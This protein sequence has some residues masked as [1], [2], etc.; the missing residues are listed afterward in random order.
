MITSLED[1]FPPQYVLNADR[2]YLSVSTTSAGRTKLKDK[3]LKTTFAL[4]FFRY[5]IIPVKPEIALQMRLL[6]LSFILPSSSVLFFALIILCDGKDI[7]KAAS[8]PCFNKILKSSSQ[9]AMNFIQ[10]VFDAYPLLANVY[11]KLATAAI[12]RARLDLRSLFMLRT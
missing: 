5:F 2:I 12:R 7:Q 10:S 11:V 3:K 6:W 4:K 8:T 1:L 9:D